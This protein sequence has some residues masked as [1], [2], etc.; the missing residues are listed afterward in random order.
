MKSYK[1]D[2]L[3]VG[4]PID[5]ELHSVDA[6]FLHTYYTD[7]IKTY[8]YKLVDIKYLDKKYS[9]ALCNAS[10]FDAIE[11]IKNHFRI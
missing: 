6:L 7:K 2:Y 3:F 9:V 11:A 5:G 8:E 1:K 4:G 10:K